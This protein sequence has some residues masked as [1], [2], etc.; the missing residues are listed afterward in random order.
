M[1]RE[2]VVI[3]IR[4]DDDAS[5]VINRVRSS[6]RNVGTAGTRAG[7]DTVRGFAG[8][9]ASSRGVI[10]SI[11]GIT[12]SLAGIG[13]IAAAGFGAKEIIGTAASYETGM[14]IFQAV[15][16][17]SAEQMKTADALAIKLG[18][19]MTLPATSALDAAAAMTELAKAGLSID[20]VFGAVKGTLQLS[21]AAQ[22]EEANAA[23]IVAT[24]LNAFKLPGEDATRVA[25]LLAASA[26]A[27]AAEITDMADSLQMSA[28]VFAAAKVPIEDLVASIG[29]MAN[30]GIAGSDAGTSLKQMVLALQNP[31]NKA[32]DAMRDLGLSI[33][34]ASGTM[35]DMRTIIG[36]FT[37]KLAIG[38]TVAIATGGATKQ[39]ATAAASAESQIGS[40]TTTL[41]EQQAQLAIEN[42][43]LADVTKKYGAGS[44]QVQRQQLAI[45]KLT[46]NIS[47]SN[48]KL[49]AAKGIISGYQAAV[50]S[51]TTAIKKMTQEE[52][53]K[54]LGVIFGSDAVRDANILLA[55]GTEQYD[56]MREAVTQAGSAQDLAAA[57]TKGL[58]GAWDGLKSQLET[59][60]LTLGKPLMAPLTAGLQTVNTWIGN[61]VAAAGSFDL[62][63]MKSEFATLDW[64]KWADEATEW[65]GDAI[66]GINRRL[67][68]VLTAI[69]N[70]INAHSV[71]IAKDV[72]KFAESFVGWAVTAAAEI[73]PKLFEFAGVVGGWVF[74]EGGAAFA[75]FG[76]ELGK[77]LIGG[78]LRGLINH[79]E[80]I[81]RFLGSIPFNPGAPFSKAIADAMAQQRAREAFGPNVTPE[82]YPGLVGPGTPGSPF[83]GP[84]APPPAIREPVPETGQEPSQEAVAPS[85]GQ[86]VRE[87]FV[88]QAGNFWTRPA[89]SD[90]PPPKGYPLEPAY[91]ESYQTMLGQSKRV[92]GGPN[93]TTL[94]LLH[95]GEDVSRGKAGNTDNRRLSIT[96]NNYGG[97]AA[98]MDRFRPFQN[99]FMRVREAF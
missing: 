18:A 13:V 87:V 25:D 50:G 7:D 24:A 75:A 70:W 82:Q 68:D 51:T 29:V 91:A 42:Q 3:R 26:N 49:Q 56:K 2:E 86:R 44:I 8:I 89:G 20:Q 98:L 36:E 64:R 40:L 73:T 97:V 14:N 39:M 96:V 65:I 48:S 55:S 58:A 16:K 95:G 77:Q 61:V 53:D 34:D 93:D 67:P 37:E 45:Q 10:S 32:R 69:K 22:I 99:Q 28:A 84:P 31:S 52:R 85:E 19:D 54:T 35:K 59:L 80:E 72:G 88:N 81:N 83:Y 57:K 43:Q 23:K 90:T 5:G 12:G 4:A 6:L 33:Y 74:G 27:S 17:A 30:A 94:A 1:S 92:P 11:T 62:G 46:N 21:A 78:I 63:H 66:G 9:R 71:D 76:V 79:Q 47:E 41:Q 15:T 60:A 38:S